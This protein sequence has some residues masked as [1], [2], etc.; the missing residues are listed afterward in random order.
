MN[1]KNILIIG[2]IISLAILTVI[3]FATH[4]ETDTSYLPRMAAIFLPMVVGWFIL[5]PWM[6]SLRDQALSLGLSVRETTNAGLFRTLHGIS[7]ALF[8]IQ[9][10]LGLTLVWRA[11]KNAD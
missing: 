7:S 1:K 3:G 6:D 11:T 2:D 8:M 4:G 10:L 5:I 9:A